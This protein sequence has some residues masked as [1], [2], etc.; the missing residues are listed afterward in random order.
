ML[1]LQFKTQIKAAAD[2]VYDTMLG[3]SNKA[4]YEQ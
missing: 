2:Q 1:K 3:I 4:T